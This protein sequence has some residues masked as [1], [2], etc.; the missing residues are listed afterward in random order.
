MAMLSNQR[1]IAFF[2]DIFS[3]PNSCN[4][5]SQIYLGNIMEI[6]WGLNLFNNNGIGIELTDYTF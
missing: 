2:S 6:Y 3:L 5:A 4:P 1:V